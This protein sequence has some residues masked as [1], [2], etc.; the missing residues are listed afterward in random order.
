VD[1]FQAQAAAV[2]VAE[3]AAAA[4]GAEVEGQ[5]FFRRRHVSPREKGEGGG[6]AGAAPS[7]QF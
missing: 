1:Y 4:L 5:E 2:E 6:A 3:D 7:G